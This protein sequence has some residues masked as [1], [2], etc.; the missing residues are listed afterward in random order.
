[1]SLVATLTVSAMAG[2]FIIFMLVL[3]FV[4]VWSN[5]PARK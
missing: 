2:A 5:L 4:S 3:G 1:M